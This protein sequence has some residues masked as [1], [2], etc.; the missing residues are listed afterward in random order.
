M[1]NSVVFR[2][3]LTFQLDKRFSNRRISLSNKA[4]LC[5]L[6]LSHNVGANT[7][8]NS[9]GP[10]VGHFL[11]QVVAVENKPITWSKRVELE[12]L[13]AGILI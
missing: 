8:I 12:I 2:R 13:E 1:E 10:R 6:C 7:T 9:N 5:V 3:F 11:K 4:C